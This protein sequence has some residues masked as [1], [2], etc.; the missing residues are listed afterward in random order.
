MDDVKRTIA[1][2]EAALK[3]DWNHPTSALWLAYMD[4]W[5]ANGAAGLPDE[6]VQAHRQKY[7]Q[8]MSFM[9]IRDII[10]RGRAL[11]GTDEVL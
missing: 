7:F 3:K 9:S 11:Q 6:K 10:E 5:N 8:G 2:E 4:L 1:E